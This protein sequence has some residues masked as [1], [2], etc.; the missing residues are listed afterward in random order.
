MK[1]IPLAFAAFLLFAAASH[2]ALPTIIV[3][4]VTPQPVEPGGDVTIQVKFYNRQDTDT[5]D[6]SVIFDSVPPILLKSSSEDLS[7]ASLCGFCNR[8]NKYFITI[9]PTAFSGTYPVYIKA[10]S[11]STESRQRVDI[12]VRGK[13]NL[14]FSTA[15]ADIDKV[16]PNEQFTAV[17]DVRNIGTGTATQIKIQPESQQFTVIG[18]A[19]RTIDSIAANETKPADFDFATA[20]SVAA[21]SYSIP[22]RMSYLDENWNL[23]NTTQNLGV[24]VID[25]GSINIQTIKVASSTGSSAVPV[26]QPFT[27]VVRLENIGPGDA[28]ALAADIQCP[29]NG[30]KKAFV[31]QLKD[32]EDAPAVFNLVAQS[33]GTFECDLIV[34]Y[35]DDLGGH[36]FAQKFDVT[37]DPQNPA[38]MVFP[39]I[40]L[41]IIVF[42]FRKR[43]LT[44]LGRKKTH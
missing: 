5:G 11:G 16:V 6:F 18:G 36:S 8:E 31:G 44:M 13:P 39:V 9:Q 30:P 28:N 42:L 34:S 20:S 38:D 4:S 35:T 17:L 32:D 43:I 19:I 27:V 24:R 7:R 2:A 40:V 3:D 21:N 29:F 25:R 41:L 22:F 12:Q 1:K 15:S 10:V 14:V 33:S 37:I 26:G 23:I